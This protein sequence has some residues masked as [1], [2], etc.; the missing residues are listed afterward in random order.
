MPH[1]NRGEHDVMDDQLAAVTEQPGQRDRSL[2]AFEQ[3]LLIDPDH[4]QP[5]PLGVERVTPA[6][7]FL[8]LGQQP[9]P[10][11]EPL[12]PRYNLGKTHHNL[13]DY[14]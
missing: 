6:G 13:L 4:G 3:V 11:L 8:L 12:L 7:H 14:G 2:T 1:P 10:G 9:Q 5:A